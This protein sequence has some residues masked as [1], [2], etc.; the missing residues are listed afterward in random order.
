MQLS[1]ARI[2]GKGA[3]LGL[4]LPG[5]GKLLLWLLAALAVGFVALVFG[6]IAALYPA[7]FTAQLTMLIAVGVI[8]LAALLIP[9]E[10]SAPFTSL[11]RLLYA[12]VVVWVAWPTYLSYHGLPGPDVN[13]PRLLYW[14]LVALWFFWFVASRDLRAQLFSRIK[15]FKPF[16]IMLFLYLAWLV[17]GSLFSEGVMYSLHYSIKLMIGPVLIFFIALSILRDRR[18][19]DVVFF[20]MVIG[21]LIA[22]AV[23]F[24]EAAKKANV[25]YDLVPS[26]FPQGT[27]AAEF[28]ADKLASDKSR[29]GAYRVM[30]TFSH[31]LT[32]GEYLVLCLPLAVYLLGYS[33]HFWVRSLSLA[34]IPAML[35]GIYLSHT[36]STLLAAGVVIASVVAFLGVRAVRQRRSFGLSVAGT[37]SIV[38]LIFALIMLA[39]VATELVVGRNAA[40]AGSSMTRVIM[41]E[42]GASRVLESPIVGHGPGLAAYKLGFLPGLGTLTIDN[43]YLSVAIDTGLIGLILFLGLLLYPIVKGFF[44]SQPLLGRDGARIS[45]IVAALL[46]FSVVKVVLSLTENLGEVF[47]LIALLAVAITRADDAEP[48]RTGRG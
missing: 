4:S 25:F 40:E 19:V 47:L 2:F 18:D 28:W 30:A 42:R 11:R 1:D 33:R 39:G 31:P 3:G 44:T 46:G 41:L 26:L 48:A 8:F 38:A 6:G 24:W 35:A 15:R 43:Y 45:V 22:C 29:A 12:L 7:S 10:A 5:V 20:L 21:A 17:L 14:A 34:A 37:F 16:V 36:R 13:P 27:A 9:S 32:F 23:G